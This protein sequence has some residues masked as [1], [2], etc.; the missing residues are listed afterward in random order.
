MLDRQARQ[1]LNISG[2]EFLR[3][4]DDGKY[5]DHVN[6]LE[7]PGIRRLARLVPFARD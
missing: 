2:E 5:A 1:L 4:W 7:Q 3:R 6:D